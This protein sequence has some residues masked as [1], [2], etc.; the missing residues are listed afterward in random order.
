MGIQNQN[1]FIVG[2]AAIGK[3]VLDDKKS[4]LFAMMLKELALLIDKLA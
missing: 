2:V 3:I 4:K 1:Q